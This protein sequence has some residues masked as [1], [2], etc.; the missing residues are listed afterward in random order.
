MEK[1]TKKRIKKIVIQNNQKK[2]VMEEKTGKNSLENLD[3]VLKAQ[4]IDKKGEDVIAA[5]QVDRPLEDTPEAEIEG[6]EEN[7]ANIPL[8]VGVEAGV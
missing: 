2:E 3:N 4:D 7:I 5:L 1:K 8:L 6:E